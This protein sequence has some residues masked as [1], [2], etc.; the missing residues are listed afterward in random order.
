MTFNYDLI[1][2]GFYDEIFE[3]KDGMRKF[4]HWHKFHSVVRAIQ[5]AP[6]KRTLLD[7]G[8][9]AGSFAGRF[10]DEN[11]FESLSVDILE[12]QIEYAQSKFG[13]PH[14]RFK[15]YH[16][17]ID[18][19][20][21]TGD[22]KFDIVTFI[23][24]I[25]HLDKHHI[26][27]FFEA[28]DKVTKKGSQ[29]IITTPNYASL[30]PLLEILVNKLSDVKY[31]EQHITKFTYWNIVNK[32]SDIY[33]SLLDKYQVCLLTSTHLFSPYLAIFNYSLA[34]RISTTVPAR[35]WK[36]PFGSLL[37]LRLEKK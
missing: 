15:S 13:S 36:V 16:E 20:S 10:L 11:A 34:Q 37:L 33:P 23:E 35:Q 17:F 32:L 21:V 2:S 26:R 30:W 27:D 8:C 18:L 31:E 9:F 29:V 7:V 14:K 6:G 25:E 22:T 28:I 5:P 24:V 19:V 4:W 12:D 3:G 1:P